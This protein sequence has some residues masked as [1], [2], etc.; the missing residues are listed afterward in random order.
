[1][2]SVREARRQRR[3]KRV[4]RR[5]RYLFLVL[6]M[7]CHPCTFHVSSVSMALVLLL[8]QLGTYLITEMALM[9]PALPCSL[10]A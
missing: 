4:E 5:M 7:A 2:R 3:R 1:M 6:P 8:A 9:R 10:P